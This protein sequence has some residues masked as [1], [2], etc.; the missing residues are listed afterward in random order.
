MRK[1]FKIYCDRQ[2]NQKQSPPKYI[3]LLGDHGIL[4][5]LVITLKQQ[6]MLDTEV[7]PIQ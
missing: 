6:C 3:I 1:F 5:C 7:E 4:V 2:T